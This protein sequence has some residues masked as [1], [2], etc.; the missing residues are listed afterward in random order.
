MFLTFFGRELLDAASSHHVHESPPVMLA[1][2]TILAALSAL[3]GYIGLPRILGGG[4]WFG[5]FLAPSVGAHEAHLA[6]GT[7]LFLMAASAAIALAGIGAAYLVYVRKEGAPTRRLAERLPGA[8]R[9]VA[10]KYFVD[11]AYE[12]VFV[13]GALALGRVAAWF[14]AEVVDGLVNGTAA[15]A[16]GVS[17]LAIGFDGGIIDGAVNGVG[18]A[19]GAFSRALRRL[20]TGFVYNYALAVVF[21]LVVILSLVVTI[22]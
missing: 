16:R 15:L 19:F 17:R 13:G 6:A 2:L 4:A 21:G 1:P 12:K 10:G 20:Q 5:R 14:D 18:R 7:E 8:Y 9:L 22:L 3:G 11:E